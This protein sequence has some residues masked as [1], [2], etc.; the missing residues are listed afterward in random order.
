MMDKI[1]V[2]LYGGKSIFKGVRETPLRRMLYIATTISDVTFSKKVS[3]C[4]K[5]KLET[6]AGS[7][8][9]ER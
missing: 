2:S 5:E 6:G 4:I 3:A 7:A 9:T 8:Y 1:N